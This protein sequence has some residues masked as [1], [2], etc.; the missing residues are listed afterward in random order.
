MNTLTFIEKV[1]KFIYQ[2]KIKLGIV[3]LRKMYIKGGVEST[4]PFDDD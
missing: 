1:R 4:Y 3:T 2:V